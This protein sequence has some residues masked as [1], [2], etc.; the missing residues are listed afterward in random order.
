MRRKKDGQR[1]FEIRV[2][3]GGQ[4]FC[5]SFPSRGASPIPRAWSDKR[6]LKEAEKA[7][8]LFELECQRG[9]VSKDKRSFS[10]YAR[11]VLELKEANKALKGSTLN[12]YRLIA[13]RLQGSRLGA[14]RL[15]DIKARDLNALYFELAS[16]GANK[17]TGGALS[18]GTIRKYHAFISSVLHNAVKEQLINANAAEN[19]TLPKAAAVEANYFDADKLAAI[20]DAA[21]LEPVF[22]CAMIYLFI[23]TG[24]RRGEISGLRWSDIDFQNGRIS[25]MRNVIRTGGGYVEDTPKTGV[26]R[27]VSVPRAVLDML[28]VWETEQASSFGGF[29]PSGYVFANREPLRFFR[30]DNITQYFHRFGVRYKLGR[31][32]PHA[33]R[34]TQASLLLRGG[35]DILM[36]SRRLGHSRTSTTLDIYGH[37]LEQNDLA[38]AEKVGKIFG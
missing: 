35:G 33:F 19:A 17:H 7:A 13:E 34:H 32:N 15:C 8:A 20:L 4:V 23:G 26:G 12:E 9:A 21:R 10:E 27:V 2:M 37:L 36:T 29:F 24:A 14:M 25:I 11:Y 3:Y 1:V 18:G 5:A 16:L 6:A 30:P 28:E 38:A 31:V 22:W